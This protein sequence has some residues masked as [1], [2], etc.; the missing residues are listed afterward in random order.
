M[1]D[2]VISAEPLGWYREGERGRW[3]AGEQGGLEGR[4]SLSSQSGV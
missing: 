3:E 2:D 1:S 4:R